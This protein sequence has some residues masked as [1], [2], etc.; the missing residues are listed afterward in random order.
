[1]NAPVIAAVDLGPSTARVLFHAVAFA[2]LLQVPLKVLHV[3]SDRTDEMRQRLLEA[4]LQLG[5]YQFDF[6]DSQVVIRSGRVSDAIAREALADHATLVVVGSRGHSSVSTLLLGSTS[7]SLLKNATAPVLLV[8]P[9]DIDIAAIDDGVKL[10]CGPVLAAVDLTE[11]SREQL[12]VAGKLAQIGSQPLL[13][14]TVAK[15]RTTDHHATAQ[16]R[17]R[18]HDAP[19]ARPH[20]VIVRRGTVADEIS[21]CALTEGAGLVVMG[22]RA[23]PRCQPGAIAT[24]VLRTRRAFVLAV[25][26]ARAAAV[27]RPHWRLSPATIVLLAMML[28]VPVLASGRQAFPDSAAITAFQ[29]AADSYAFVHRQAERRIG[30][31]HK[32]AGEDSAIAAA[33]LAQAIVAERKRADVGPMFTPAS[34]AAFRQIAAHAVHAGCDA[35]ELK[36][37]VWEMVHQVNGPATNA[38]RLTPCMA[39]ALPHLPEELEYRSAGTVLLLVD[40][41]AN[42]V[43]DI[44]PALLAGSDLR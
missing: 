30:Q 43:V 4:C 14:M 38:R 19:A 2:R 21:R 17:E 36:T 11:D 26:P 6:D 12:Q 18:A 34:A 13:L 28:T 5:P 10:T 7:E 44:L 8:P 31:A 15:S 37:G 33:E 3:S 32:R 27:E 40:V 24:A 41:H 1:M 20:A 35:G 29:R 23:S 39:A 25:P 9:N 16:L 22:L 42:L